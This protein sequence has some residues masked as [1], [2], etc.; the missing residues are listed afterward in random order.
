MKALILGPDDDKRSA[1]CAMLRARGHTVH[2]EPTTE[3]AWPVYEH[4]QP[5]LILLMGVNEGHVAFVRRVRAVPD[6]D[7][8]II[9][10]FQRTV[11]G[12]MQAARDAGIDGCLRLGRALEGDESR[13][14]FIERRVENRQEQQRITA[15]SR[16]RARQQAVAA[17]I[18]Q[19][20]LAGTPLDDLMAYAA[21]A[22][23][24][25]LDVDY[26]DVLECAEEARLTVRASTGPQAAVS[27]SANGQPA[28]AMALAR[29]VL[30]TGQ[31]VVVEN[32]DAETR[33]Q[34]S[35]LWAQRDVTSGVGVVVRGVEGAFGV[36]SVYT[37][38]PRAFD[39]EDVHFLQSVANALAGAVERT[40]TEQA[41]RES[42]AKA[43]AI[44]ETTVDGVI[45]IDRQGRIESF[46]QAAES[47]F[48]YRAEEVIGQNVKVLM[49]SPY[50]EE[51]DGYMR[52]YRET[53]RRKIIGI[54]REVTGRRKDG[55]TFPMDLAVS[56]VH[57]GDRRI[58][59]GIVRDITERRQL[60]KEILDITEQERRRIGQDLH[61]G[62]GQ[63][64]TGIGLL[65]QNMTRQLERRKVSEAEEAAEIT[66]LVKEADQY[67][68]DLARGLTPVDLEAS[69]LVAALRRLVANAERLF[70]IE[71]AF[72][73]VGSALVH[74]GTPATHMY[75]I[76]QEAVSNAVRHGQAKRIK[77]SL[78]AGAEQIRLRVQDDGVGFSDMEHEGPGMG[79]HIM[80]YRARI[81]GGTLDISSRPGSGTAVTFTLPQRTASSSARATD[82]T[83]Q[84][85]RHA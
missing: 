74:D 72:D 25:A 4:E 51:H 22:I 6:R 59:T 44:V 63:M 77:I 16:A 75:R 1:L 62:L 42:E 55:S 79:I 11:P 64:L 85:E 10:L 14:L 52:S 81:V 80:R 37:R 9:T 8:V 65:C 47:I 61:D 29:Y 31:P 43:R 70:D 2:V 69:G 45:T 20:A 15:E 24:D 82:E 17:K 83:T 56:E 7:T 3:A 35:A 46:N 36:L 18:S 71:C 84:S 21:D 30:R 57:L 78:A 34:P 53:G 19:R 28:R 32:I 40:H 50:H 66:D 26:C 67:A 73:E 12:C 27:S 58:F 76:A 5:A 13:L 33:F 41:L 39:T 68:R 23:V 54:G 49:P 60:E 38:D 48:G